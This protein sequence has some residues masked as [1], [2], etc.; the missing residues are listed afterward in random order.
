MLAQFDRRYWQA[1]LGIVIVIWLTLQFITLDRYPIANCDEA[2]W[3]ELAFNLHTEG[4]I[5]LDSLRGQGQT[6]LNVTPASRITT[7]LIALSQT[8]LGTSLWSSRLPALLSSVVTAG[9]LYLAG[10]DVYDE[11]VGLAAGIFYLFSWRMLLQ[12]HLGRPEATLALFTI[13]NFWLLYRIQ[14][15]RFLSD[16]FLGGLIAA[17]TVDVHF[18]GLAI[19]LATALIFLLFAVREGAWRLVVAFGVGGVLGLTF[20]LALHVFGVE[21][22]FFYQMFE[23]YRSVGPTNLNFGSMVSGLIDLPVYY[24]REFGP[25]GGWQ[26]IASFPFLLFGLGFAV[27]D[28]RIGARQLHLYF[29]VAT[30]LHATLVPLR[31]WYGALIWFPFLLL[32]TSAALAWLAGKL[33]AWTLLERVPAW[34]ISYGLQ[35]TLATIF[36]GGSLWLMYRFRGASLER[37]DEA[38]LGAL[39]T[40]ATLLAPHAFWYQRPDADEAFVSTNVASWAIYVHG[41]PFDEQVA[42]DL[43]AELA[44]VYV[45]ALP[46]W[47]CLEQPSSEYLVIHPLLETQ[48]ER[49]TAVDGGDYPDAELFYC[50]AAP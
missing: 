23:F 8:L 46:Q 18:S 38:L 22:I 4:R 14:L 1:F 27:F 33:E 50:P 35:I 44:P 41:R 15:R 11:K 9:V 42:R 40:D 12:G 48:C 29:V 49:V 24:W 31:S 30:L 43:L 3:S 34:M 45:V 37:Y 13:L 21:D 16:S 10:K 19:A 47:Q 5:A 26:N 36:L 20:W 39:P 32:L 6:D 2:F 17:L 7:L 25:G 28:R